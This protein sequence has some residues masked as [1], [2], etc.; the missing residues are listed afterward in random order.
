MGRWWPEVFA[1]EHPRGWIQKIQL[2]RGLG[3]GSWQ[4]FL[5][6]TYF[7]EGRTDLSLEAIGGPIASP[8][9]SVLE[10]PRKHIATCNFPGGV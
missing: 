1:G 10:F 5:S 3:A 2:G 8:G 9:W 4:L 6:S 7:T